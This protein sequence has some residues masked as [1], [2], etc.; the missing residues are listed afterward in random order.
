MTGREY[1]ECD[2]REEF[3]RNSQFLPSR[4]RDYLDQFEDWE[5]AADWAVEWIADGSGIQG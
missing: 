4:I 1:F 2:G 3:V 5:E